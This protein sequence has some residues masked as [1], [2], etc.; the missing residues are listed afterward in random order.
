MNQQTIKDAIEIASIG[1]GKE[2]YRSYPG[3]GGIWAG[4]NE[5]FADAT[6]V[7]WGLARA[8][9]I[10]LNAAVNGDLVLKTEQGK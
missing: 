3:T 7:D 10:I 5:Q 2:G 8:A 9:A 1:A 6:F 4:R